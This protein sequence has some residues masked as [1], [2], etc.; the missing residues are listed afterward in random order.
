MEL[1]RRL[2]STT[3]KQMK[4]DRTY[5]I[6]SLRNENQTNFKSDDTDGSL[7]SPTII[8]NP[9]NP[10]IEEYQSIPNDNIVPI[11]EPGQCFCSTCQTYDRN[12]NTNLWQLRQTPL[13]KSYLSLQK[14]FSFA[15][16]KPISMIF[17]S[18]KTTK[19]NRNDM[20]T[21]DNINTIRNSLN[22]SNNMKYSDKDLEK[23]LSST[24]TI[25]PIKRSTSRTSSITSSFSDDYP[26]AIFVNS[27]KNQQKLKP[28]EKV[29]L[30]V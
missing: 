27:T 10:S 8:I 7:L 22:V 15:Q 30:Y 20:N 19:E 25:K 5:T 1:G 13:K 24:I 2:S 23:D 29:T 9:F 18:T 26:E 21:S 6:S 14:R 3:Q 16:L 17:S 4:Q 12:D 28:K 11:T